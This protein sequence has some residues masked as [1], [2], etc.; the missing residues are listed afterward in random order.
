MLPAQAEARI[1]DQQHQSLYEFTVLTGG[2]Y[3]VTIKAHQQTTVGQIMNHLLAVA[4]A[5]PEGV[6]VLLAQGGEDVAAVA[7][8]VLDKAGLEAAA[9]SFADVQVQADVMAGAKLLDVVN[10]VAASAD[11][12]AAIKVV[13]AAFE[14]GWIARQQDPQSEKAK[15][16]RK[17][18]KSE[19]KTVLEAV[20]NVQ[21]FQ[22]EVMN[23]PGNVQA[24][25]KK[26]REAKNGGPKT[27]AE[28]DPFDAYCAA[29]QQAFELAQKQDL[30]DDAATLA[31]LLRNVGIV[32]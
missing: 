15:N 24:L 32:V 13:L 3:G 21:G 28:K 9:D 26:A 4:G 6:T 12:V 20:A 8:P 25:A 18:R 29:L 23:N 5:V 30:H 17:V 19:L 7:A 16:I 1:V 10:L 2:Y 22:D 27:K 14:A 31:G 11:P